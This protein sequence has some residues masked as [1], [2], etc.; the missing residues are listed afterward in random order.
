M[1]QLCRYCN[2]SNKVGGNEWLCLRGMTIAEQKIYEDDA[3]AHRLVI[4][5]N[6]FAE[7]IARK[8]IRR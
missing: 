1:K 2:N 8:Y 4:M 6:R 7:R 5:G 3:R